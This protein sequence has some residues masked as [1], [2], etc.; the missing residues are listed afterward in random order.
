M[1]GRLWLAA[2]YLGILAG[3]SVNG[4]PQ[5]PAGVADTPA[6]P[7]PVLFKSADRCQAC[8]NGL[9]AP[10]GE[11]ISFGVAWRASMMAQSARDPYW[12]AAVRRETMDHPSAAAAIERECSRCHMPMAHVTEVAAGAPPSLFAN[13]PPHAAGP[14]AALAADGVSCTACHQ[15]QAEGLGTRESF[16]GHFVVDTT[17]PAGE[18]Q[19]FGPFAVDPGLEQVMRSATEFTPVEGR[20]IRSSEVCA[21]CHTLFTN[22]LDAEG[23]AVGR[24]AEQVP[25][26]E[27]LHSAYRETTSCQGCHMPVVGEPVRISSTLGQPREGVARHSFRGGNVWMLKV[28][29]RYRADLGVTTLPQELEAAVRETVAHLREETAGVSIDGVERDG[30]TLRFEVAVTNRAGHKLPTAYP[31]RRVWLHVAVRDARGATLFESGALEPSGLIAGNDN[32]RDPSAFE[33]HHAEI[34]SPDQV[35]IYE[36]ILGDARG[37]V[38]TGL[39]TGVRYLKDNRLL[40]RGFDKTTAGKD[41]AVLGGAAGDGDFLAPGDRVRYSVPVTGSGPLTVTVDLRYQSIGYRWAHKLRQRS[42]T[43]TDR[44]VRYYESMS[45]VTSEWLARADARVP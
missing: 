4:Q 8:H 25:Y 41:I 35:Q 15:I 21:T 13:L 34:T 9:L 26:L 31:S 19:V 38:T 6:G 7:A 16:T 33:P 42:A 37:G 14:H 32:D 30:E 17:T 29:N 10:S 28:L 20:H 44:L 12:Q 22:A 24:L 3:S 23:Q 27:W 2:V 18:R 11:D 36:S 39:L 45:A 5:R 40:P 43:E 1:T